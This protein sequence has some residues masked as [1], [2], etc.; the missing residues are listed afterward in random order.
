MFSV[1][2]RGDTVEIMFREDLPELNLE[3]RSSLIVTVVA[4]IDDVVI[5]EIV[6]IFN[7]QPADCKDDLV[8][9]SAALYIGS[10]TTDFRVNINPLTLESTTPS[11]VEFTSDGGKFEVI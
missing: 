2:H 1:E 11:N 6:V 9:F 10:I 4:K 7:I 5:D 3:D 8:V